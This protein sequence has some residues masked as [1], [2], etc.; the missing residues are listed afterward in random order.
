MCSIVSK[1]ELALVK[2][3]GEYK[4]LLRFLF[5]NVICIFEKL[6]LVLGR[7]AKNCSQA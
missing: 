1:T 3:F 6:R 4:S 7:S 2:I 5:T